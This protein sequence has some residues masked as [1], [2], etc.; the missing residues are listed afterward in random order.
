M[1]F[2]RNLARPAESR[3]NGVEMTLMPSSS[4]SARSKVVVTVD[5]LPSVSCYQQEPFNTIL[6]KPGWEFPR[7]EWGQWFSWCRASPK[8]MRL[9]SMFDERS[10]WVV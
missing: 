10:I 7:D 6:A 9:V 2:D 3:E 1:V 5:A 8:T 4:W